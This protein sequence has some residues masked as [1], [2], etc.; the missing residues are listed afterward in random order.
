VL[1]TAEAEGL[2]TPDLANRNSGR[3][4]AMDEQD[5]PPRQKAAAS[6]LT[7]TDEHGLEM[8]QTAEAEGLNTPDLA[9][10][11]KAVDERL[12]VKKR[13]G[14][15]LRIIEH[16]DEAIKL[17]MQDRVNCP[18]SLQD[19]IRQVVAILKQKFGTEVGYD[20][21]GK[22][23]RTLERRINNA[24]EEFCPQGQNS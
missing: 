6:L 20:E 7:G 16:D 18:R 5:Q 13:T 11:F 21:G 14:R 1:R 3:F 9:D 10:R 22:R 8:I 19:E 17:M 2:T 23:C 4:N 12:N 15:R 24:W